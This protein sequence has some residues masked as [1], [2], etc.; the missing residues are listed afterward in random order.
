MRYTT[1]YNPVHSSVG[2]DRTLVAI[3]HVHAEGARSSRTE[4]GTAKTPRAPS[5]GKRGRSSPLGTSNNLG[6]LGVLAVQL[7][8]S[9]CR[10]SRCRIERG[11]ARVRFFRAGPL[12]F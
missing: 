10:M 7:I 4:R 6:D 11:P 1:R 9:R 2:R 3:D 12:G 5:L 8:S